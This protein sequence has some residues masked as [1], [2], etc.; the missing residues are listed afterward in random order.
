MGNPTASPTKKL[1]VWN[2]SGLSEKCIGSN[3]F[4]ASPTLNL[5]SGEEDIPNL[6]NKSN[7]F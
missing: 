4:H 1:S 7:E 2:F 3:G 5:S 6:V